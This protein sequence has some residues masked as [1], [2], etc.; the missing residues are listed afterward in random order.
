MKLEQISETF[1][2]KEDSHCDCRCDFCAVL[3][4]GQ[5]DE[6]PLVKP[7]LPSTKHAD[8][9]SAKGE[10]QDDSPICESQ[11][12]TNSEESTTYWSKDTHCRPTEEQGG[13]R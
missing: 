8:K 6:S 3:K 9:S 5:R 13:D 4:D 10:E 12:H 1:E 2:G 11:Y 7:H